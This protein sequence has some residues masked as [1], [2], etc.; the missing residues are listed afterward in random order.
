MENL[1]VRLVHL[2]PV[3]VAYS[4]GFGPSPEG[5]AW[6]TLLDWASKAGQ[7]EDWDAHRFFGFNNPDPSPG[8]PNY[9]YEQWMTLT[10]ELLP[11]GGVKVKEVPGGFYAVAR[12]RGTEAIFPTWQRLVTWVEESRY[13]QG[14]SQCLEEC[15]NPKVLT[16]GE[17]EPAFDQLE[18][19]LY[20]PVTE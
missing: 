3:R 11:D 15:L 5:E 17:G 4:L 16:L 1:E 8:S 12:C 7:L 18:F 6:N 19:D 10:E 9:G 13:Q 14:Y 20:L 2:E